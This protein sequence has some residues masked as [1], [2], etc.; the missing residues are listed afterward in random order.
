MMY[1]PVDLV[2][3]PREQIAQARSE[4]HEP[5]CAGATGCCGPVDPIDAAL[6]AGYA[7]GVRHAREMIAYR[8]RAELVCCSG[9]EVEAMAEQLKVAGFGE[10]PVG[11]H[12]I[13]YWGEMSARLVEDH[14]SM[15]RSPYECSGVHPG[16]CWSTRRC[17]KQEHV[18]CDCFVCT[19]CE[20]HEVCEPPL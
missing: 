15:L 14:H 4:I 13:C 12:A 2:R 6:R 5:C 11:F 7:R 9:E 16:E 17:F 1:E 18:I 19:V 10:P 20:P 3:E 8:V